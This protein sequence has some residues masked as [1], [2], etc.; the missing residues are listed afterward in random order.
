M[1]KILSILCIAITFSTISN[2][3]IAGT[4]SYTHTDREVAII[5]ES[6]GLYTVAS[7]IVDKD[8]NVLVNLVEFTDRGPVYWIDK[9]KKPDFDRAYL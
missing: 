9:I 6:L 2:S 7:Q 1:K 4:L 8:G 5:A 3:S